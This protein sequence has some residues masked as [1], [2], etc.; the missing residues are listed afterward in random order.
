M[1]TTIF[2]SM[3]LLFMS[4][5]AHQVYAQVDS[6]KQSYVLLTKKV[7]QLQP[8]LMSAEALKKEDASS[9][10]QFEIIICGQQIG[11]IT[12]PDKISK[13]L[14]KAESLGVTLVA[15]G[16]SLD[17][18]NVDRSKVPEQMKIVENGILYNL[19]LQKRGYFSLGL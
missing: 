15:C 8:I 2:T 4:L 6:N 1:R 19:Q 9:F 5:T 14:A 7:P 12:D 13:F 17:K 11:D 16:F 18:F 3:L 10:G